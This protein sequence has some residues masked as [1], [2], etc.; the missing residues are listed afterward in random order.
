[1]PKIDLRS[2][3]PT[4][5][6]SRTS[7]F[8]KRCAYTS[9]LPYLLARRYGPPGFSLVSSEMDFQIGG[10]LPFVTRR[11]DGREIVQYGAYKE[12]VPPERIVNTE[13]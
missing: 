8:S 1:M 3:S 5:A 10:A 9:L 7:G 2:R 4:T 6:R 13:R 11:T 12:I